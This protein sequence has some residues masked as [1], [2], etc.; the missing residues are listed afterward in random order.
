MVVAAVVAGVAQ[1]HTDGV[2]LAGPQNV[3]ASEIQARTAHY[4]VFGEVVAPVFWR[5]RG[6]H[7]RV[8]DGLRC[9]SEGQVVQQA[10]QG[11]GAGVDGFVVAN[12]PVVFPQPCLPLPRG[13]DIG[14]AM[15]RAALAASACM[16]L[17][18]KGGADL[19]VRVLEQREKLPCAAG[20]GAR[21]LC[22]AE[23]EHCQS[24]AQQFMV[25]ELA[26]GFV[27]RGVGP[28]QGLLGLLVANLN[29]VE[30]FHGM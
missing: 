6:L 18:Q 30:G 29:L 2:A 27:Q 25:F 5:G 7:E 10:L 20:K 17:G 15:A 19:V 23:V 1:G 4:L 16:A 3:V 12:T 26:H 22:G 13:S 21:I 24:P 8:D 11:S 9:L 28:Y 14:Q